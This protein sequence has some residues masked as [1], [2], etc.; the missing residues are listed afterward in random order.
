[1]DQATMT[2]MN[3]SMAVKM[4]T[5]AVIGGPTKTWGGST[6]ADTQAGTQDSN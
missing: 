6:K 5:R 2:M 3:V 4:K 1:M